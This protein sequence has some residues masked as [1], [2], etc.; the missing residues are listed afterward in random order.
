MSFYDKFK[1]IVFIDSNIILEGKP[2][3]DL[4]WVELTN[5]DPIVILFVPQVLKEVDKRKR[6]GRLGRFAREFSRLISSA[7]NG[8]S[9]IVRE[10][11]PR[12]EVGLAGIHRIKW[13]QYDDLDPDD[14]DARVIAE[15]IH[16]KHVDDKTKIIVSNDVNPLTHAHRHGIRA[17]HASEM[18]MRPPEP[19][20]AEK[21]VQRLNQRIR[22]LEVTQPKLGISIEC[23][24]N[25]V[26]IYRVSDLTS[27]EVEKIE[28]F[29]LRK[30]SRPIPDNILHGINYDPGFEDN[31]AKYRDQ[32]VPNF[33]INFKKYVELTYNQFPIKIKIVNI[34]QIRAENLVVR[35]NVY[36]GWLHNKYVLFP[37]GGPVPPIPQDRFT[38]M[39]S[40][41][42]VPP[43]HPLVGRHEIEYAKEPNCDNEVVINCE[44]FRHGQAWEF[45]GFGCVF[46]HEAVEY[47]INVEATAGNLNGFIKK[48]FRVDINFSD[49]DISHL[50]NIEDMKFVRPF[51]MKDEFDKARLNRSFKQF[52]LWKYN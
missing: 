44:D 1:S 16:A 48:N 47:K 2:L 13:N 52:K 46:A 6:D 50:V 27:E 39:L 30:H 38:R 43:V 20:P 22:D 4:P 23:I 37:L 18:W 17:F 12:V 11:S 26:L 8:E 41:I 10:H 31:Y 14:A 25:P 29:V 15:I 21:E 9:V 40:Q 42:D 24:E 36:S 49:V 3:K 33:A 5:E 45:D 19:S 35:I 51:R 28:R 32:D 34:G 7:I